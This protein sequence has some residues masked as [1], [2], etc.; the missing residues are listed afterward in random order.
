MDIASGTA[1]P[2]LDLRSVLFTSIASHTLCTLLAA[3]LWWQNR[4]H[5]NGLAHW[6]GGAVM[7]TAGLTLILLRPV[8]PEWGSMLAGNLLV[9]GGAVGTLAG[10]ARF[11]GIAY[12]QTHN[13]L[14]LALFTL[15]QSHLLFVRPD[16]TSRAV[17]IACVLALLCA[18]G[19]WLMVRRAEPGLRPFTRGVGWVYGG[20]TLLFLHRAVT[21][22]LRPFASQ[23]YYR[24]GLYE[25]LF[26]IT[27]QLFFVLLTY[28][29]C[30][31]V[32]RRLI[33]TAEAEE[34]KFAQIFHSAPYSML[35]TRLEDGTIL[36]ANACF[37]R[38]LG[39]PQAEILG[40][41][42]REL[43]LW[44]HPEARQAMVAELRRR[45][46]LHH[47]ETVLNRKNGEPITV[48]YSAEIVT[49]NQ[50]TC[51]LYSLEDV[52][53]IR[54]AEAERERLLADREKALSEIKVLSGLLPICAACKKIR[55]DSGYWN[56]IESYI[57]QHSE[58]EF[59][60]GLCP[61]CLRTLYPD[62]QP[63]EDGTAG[64]ALAPAPAIRYPHAES[65]TFQKGHDS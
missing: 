21:L 12:R 40:K 11:A 65:D 58:A 5:V 63:E 14:L 36:D 61:D 46:G 47:V 38:T 25:S 26:Q 59:S 45:G 10:L 27:A 33:V 6:F 41:T 31:M 39:F 48:L 30:L 60:H 49:L 44:P 52:T 22:T 4:R 32:N 62:L 1:L 43:N 35:I 16:L 8:V 19:F 57:G 42:T 56:Q 51:I 13:L 34:R 29:L 24:S 7:Q 53:E 64:A 15:V 54:Q 37:A 28:S 50:E 2:A 17:L 18:Q 23:D 3:W 55:D 9:I 20:Y